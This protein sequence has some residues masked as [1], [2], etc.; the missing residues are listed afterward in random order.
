[1]IAVEQECRDARLIEPAH[2]AAEEQTGVVVTPVSVVQ[3]AGDHQEIDG[4]RDCR[5]HER[6][7]GRSRRGPQHPDRRALIAGESDERAVEMNVCS[8]NEADHVTSCGDES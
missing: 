8:V 1:M 2:L 6:R 3:I 4:L 7:E 5:V